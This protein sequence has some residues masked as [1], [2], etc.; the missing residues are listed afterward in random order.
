[1]AQY[2]LSNE[3][4]FK[5]FDYEATQADANVLDLLSLKALEEYGMQAY[6]V[7]SAD[8]TNFELISAVCQTEAM[9]C[10]TGM[11]TERR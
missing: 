2:Q 5:A 8:F 7:A 10:S 1:M 3:D 4:L 11:S 6:K 9:F